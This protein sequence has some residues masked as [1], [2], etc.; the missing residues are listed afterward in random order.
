MFLI[1]CR[2]GKDESEIAQSPSSK[3]QLW[4]NAGSLYWAHSKAITDPYKCSPKSPRN[5]KSKINR[6]L[7]SQGWTLWV[8][9]I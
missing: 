7:S 6:G 2:Q 1:I 5:L 9:I 4:E 3:G 8:N